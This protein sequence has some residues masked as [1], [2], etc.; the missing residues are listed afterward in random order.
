MGVG[1]GDSL[2]L[3]LLCSGIEIKTAPDI[4]LHVDLRKKLW[5][6][7]QSRARRA[8]ADFCRHS[9]QPLVAMEPRR[10]EGQRSRTMNHD[11][12]MDINGK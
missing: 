5:G 8:A 12:L 10:S 3:N 9:N 6:R 7:R 2:L 1:V 11:T 4:R